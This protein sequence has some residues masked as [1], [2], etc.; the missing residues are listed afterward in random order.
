MMKAFQ[1]IRSFLLLGSA[2]AV[3]LSAVAA[4]DKANDP[5]ALSAEETHAIVQERGDEVLF[6]DVRD[7]VE[8]MFTGAT[9]EVD[10][11]IPF[12]LMDRDRQGENGMFAMPR[13]PHFTEEVAAALEE[14]GLSRDARIIT[15]CRSGSARGRPSAEF[16]RENGFPNT[17]YV[18][19][20]FQGGKLAGGMRSK[21]GWQN[22]GLPWTWSI[23]GDKVY[24]VDR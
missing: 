16:L 11:N 12:L 9:N 14:K 8:L 22:E 15:M 24:R 2:F 5:Y 19:N 20:G 1:P 13:N 21:N 18:R 4:P 7:P 17:Y 6:L 3:G 23:D 10:A